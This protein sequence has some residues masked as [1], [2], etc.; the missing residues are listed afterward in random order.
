MKTS[1]K[2]RF[3]KKITI[4]LI[5]ILVI[6]VAAVIIHSY[7]TSGSSTGSSGVGIGKR[8]NTP[9]Q[10]LLSITADEERA[11]ISSR[12]LSWRTPDSMKESSIFL[13]M[14]NKPMDDPEWDTAVEISGIINSYLPKKYGKYNH[15][16]AEITGLAPGEYS[17][18]I[19]PAGGFEALA[20]EPMSFTI[21]NAD[22]IQM[23]SSMLFFGDT[24]PD[25]SISEYELFG[26]LVKTARDAH[27]DAGVALQCGDIGNQGDS[28]EEWGAFLKVA[29]T[30]FEGMPLM[31]S[32]GNHEVS[33][34][35]NNPSRKPEFYLN[36]FSLPKNG[37][38]GLE[39]EFYS[40]DYGNIHVL[41]LSSNYMDPSE[42]YSDDEKE[43]A[44]IAA[45]VNE[46]IENDLASTYKP[47]K[48]VLMHQP[49][50]PLAGDST[51]RGI[52]E[53]WIPIF[54]RNYVDLIL[55]GHQHE[56]MRTWPQREGK[57][58]KYGLVQMMGN[59]SQKYYESSSSAPSFV[60]FEAGGISGY[61]SIRAT[62][63]ELSV[64]A[65]NSA[66]KSIDFWSKNKQ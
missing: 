13:I 35:V 27:P 38:E 31:T 5:V 22:D 52:N 30:S 59:A 51:T 19:A 54:D 47:W 65:Y 7:A 4:A 33:P 58:N 46:W 44:E 57:E 11:D 66:G 26:E 48:I 62:E 3:D 56:F 50:F 41:S 25:A 53:Q 23:H 29:Q 20:S 6:A 17:Y 45:K 49:A 24:Q 18:V 63:K 40:F 37:P 43:A 1:K 15:F 9:D 28:P 8:S 16:E 21:P 64:E 12:T 36:V 10:I 42:T 14:G 60:A 2:F 61:H 39:E 34:Y 55:C 32:P